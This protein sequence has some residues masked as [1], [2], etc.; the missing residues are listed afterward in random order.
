MICEIDRSHDCREFVKR[1]AEV[2]GKIWQVQAV[3]TSERLA[4]LRV[5]NFRRRSELSY[6]YTLTRSGTAIC[7]TR[8]RERYMPTVCTAHDPEKGHRFNPNKLVL[9]PHAKAHI[10]QLK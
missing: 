3:S 1:S 5:R 6:R 2:A 8:D 4:S 10:G 7:P 9:D